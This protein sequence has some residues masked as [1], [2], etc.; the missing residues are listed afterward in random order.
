MEPQDDDVTAGRLG[1]D[2]DL[3]AG[4]GEAEGGVVLGQEADGEQRGE[5]VP[6]L[7]ELL[8]GVLLEPRALPQVAG[9]LVDA[10]FYFERHQRI[11]RAMLDL[12]QAGT[13]V[14]LRTLQ[15]R[16][17]HC[18][19]YANLT[20]YSDMTNPAAA[21]RNSPSRAFTVDS[22]LWISRLAPSS[23][24]AHATAGGTATRLASP[25]RWPSLQSRRRAGWPPPLYEAPP[26]PL[27]RATGGRRP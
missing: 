7:G 20:H 15:G 5:V 12:Q 13:T 16:L 8:A 22:S 4:L 24:A 27:P 26:P 21:A 1:G 17:E 19:I 6:Q 23:S 11:Y 10:D 2:G 9:R 14:D 18:Y 25:A 3:Q